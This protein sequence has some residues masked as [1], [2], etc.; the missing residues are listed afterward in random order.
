MDCPLVQLARNQKIRKKFEEA[1]MV[2]IPL[3]D[4]I[5]FF[6]ALAFL[7]RGGAWEISCAIVGGYLM[8]SKTSFK[9]K[10]DLTPKQIELFANLCACGN[11]A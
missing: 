9:R 3:T 4:W 8:L 1:G 11:G 5:R 2:A 10:P 6:E 7:D